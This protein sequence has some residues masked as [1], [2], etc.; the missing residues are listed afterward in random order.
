[1]I[2]DALPRVL[3]RKTSE[4]SLLHKVA[5][6]SSVMPLYNVLIVGVFLRVGLY[7][8][9]LSTARLIPVVVNASGCRASTPKLRAVDKVIE[10]LHILDLKS[11]PFARERRRLRGW[12]IAI[13][14]RVIPSTESLRGWGR[15][16]RAHR[17]EDGGIG[18]SSL[19]TVLN[20]RLAEGNEEGRHRR[21]HNTLEQLYPKISTCK[22]AENLRCSSRPLRFFARILQATF[23]QHPL[24]RVIKSRSTVLQTRSIGH[25]RWS[26]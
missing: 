22:M 24:L 19:S 16:R 20:Q 8:F 14:T 4:E 11:R 12:V 9:A 1:M 5:F 10:Q 17:V 25:A 15:G 6:F 18:P 13:A 26:S 2:R 3:G 23:H 21:L 7:A